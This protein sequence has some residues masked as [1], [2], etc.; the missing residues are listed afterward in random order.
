VFQLSKLGRDACDALAKQSV[1][2]VMIRTLRLTSQAALSNIANDSTELLSARNQVRLAAATVLGNL[3]NAS[4]DSSTR[5]ALAGG[6]EYAL[7]TLQQLFGLP[8]GFQN[9]SQ[10]RQYVLIDPPGAE[11][12]VAHQAIRILCGYYTVIC[13]DLAVPK[14]WERLSINYVENVTAVIN[15]VGAILHYPAPVLQSALCTLLAAIAEC[16]GNEI[17]RP[18]II[19][20]TLRDLVHLV[21]GGPQGVH[22]SDRQLQEQGE[23]VL[24]ALG[25]DDG[26]DDVHR[27]S[28]NP[29][30][31]R[32]WARIQAS[33]EFQTLTSLALKQ[34]ASEF[35]KVPAENIL[36]KAKEVSTHC[37]F[38]ATL[39][40]FF[41]NHKGAP[42]YEPPLWLRGFVGSET[43]PKPSVEV[44]EKL[45][46]ISK[47]YVTSWAKQLGFALE[48]SAFGPL[49]D[50]AAVSI[51]GIM[52][53]MP[54]WYVEMFKQTIPSLL[55]RRYYLLPYARQGH[56]SML[57]EP[58]LPELP[59]SIVVPSSRHLTKQFGSILQKIIL[60]HDPVVALEGSNSERSSSSN[61]QEWTL[62]VRE[63][64]KCPNEEFIENLLDCLRRFPSI[65]SLVLMG[66]S[67]F[68]YR[69]DI[70]AIAK[71]VRFLP[72]SV[73]WLTFDNLLCRGKDVALVAKAISLRRTLS[74]NLSG[75]SIRESGLSGRDLQPILS[76]M[77]PT[78]ARSSLNSSTP[79]AKLRVRWL[80]FSGN[81]LTDAHCA[82]IIDAVANASTATSAV[83]GLDFSNNAILGFPTKMFQAL[84]NEEKDSSIMPLLGSESSPGTLHEL[85]IGNMPVGS[86]AASALLRRAASP[87]SRLRALGLGGCRLT[88]DSILTCALVEALE[89]GT[90]LSEVDLSDNVL[91]EVSG[92]EICLALRVHCPHFIGLNGCKGLRELD[93]S[94]IQEAMLSVRAHYAENLL[95][96]AK[97]DLL[98]RAKSDFTEVRR[99]QSQWSSTYPSMWE[100]DSALAVA[101][102]PSNGDLDLFAGSSNSMISGSSSFEMASASSSSFSSSSMSMGTVS[103]NAGEPTMH[104]MV[105]DILQDERDGFR[106]RLCV[107]FSIPLVHFG[108]D[109]QPLACASI[110]YET[111]RQMLMQTFQDAKRDI[112]LSFGFATLDRLRSEV[113]LHCRAIH[114]SGHGCRDALLFE[115]Q[116]GGARP[117]ATSVLRDL[118]GSGSGGPGT[119]KVKL[120]FVSACHSEYAGQAFVDAGVPHV[121]CV[122]VS[123][124]LQ[125]T[126][127]QA[128]TR[129]FYL[130]LA[131]GGTV[132]RAFQVATQA[133]R[134]QEQSRVSGMAASMAPA[135]RP[136][137]ADK[138]LLLPL[139]GNHDVP[140]FPGRSE[141]KRWPSGDAIVSGLPEDQERQEERRKLWWGSFVSSALPK[142]FL[143][144]NVQAYDLL[145]AIMTRRI[146]S[147]TGPSGIGKLSLASFVVNYALRR[148]NFP[149]GA[150]LIRANDMESVSELVKK[151][152][153]R[154][155]DPHSAPNS[156]GGRSFKTA[157]LSF[158]EDDNADA[159]EVR[160]E[161]LFE[162]LRYRK[163][164]L[165]LCGCDKLDN[166]DPSFRTFLGRLADEVEG[167]CI[168]M[169]SSKS[170]GRIPGYTVTNIK[171]NS[172]HHRDAALL[173]LRLALSIRLCTPVDIA[174]LMT[175]METSREVANPY[176]VLDA[177]GEH[178]FLKPL[179][180]NPRR[181]MDETHALTNQRFATIIEQCQIVMANQTQVVRSIPAGPVNSKQVSSS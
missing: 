27:A 72:E 160:R 162:L 21:L 6:V 117:V 124:R 80:D 1:A 99:S 95:A 167:M 58:L 166:N 53:S 151:L 180:G 153:D 145:A 113:T 82:S 77:Q 177:I 93:R 178:P 38:A 147:C 149:Q 125:D 24:I 127:A 159:E 17:F 131:I 45:C 37:A 75:L 19:N 157:S 12:E 28:G 68:E 36:L 120:A 108:P 152:R 89:T 144:R 60:T 155:V 34:K 134:A 33:L 129:W 46:T 92:K 97:R 135:I 8:E 123:E 105:H 98:T 114:Y 59:L 83:R 73:Q 74:M 103:P 171:L 70:K 16:P 100:S 15:T 104:P 161:Q 39:R 130:E 179:N 44:D 84:F 2:R 67:D 175:S 133:V 3:A 66:P 9:S 4:A 22:L 50:D 71:L 31:L 61:L 23:D 7:E 146:V 142:E 63:C 18:Q 35:W 122:K 10:S 96:K 48:P 57:S 106:P 43:N 91:G 64:I 81:S 109:G 13:K 128:F 41:S 143:G 170:I 30:V 76:L 42:V 107:L 85:F 47:N 116:V 78:V 148:G 150:I 25:F 101:S 112:N 26:I 119:S 40:R 69:I 121:V 126:A 14:R 154:T 90:H 111:E 137:Q 5:V 52:R 158:G 168:L 118:A 172:L 169:T 55:E 49:R 138:F 174:K 54:A 139:D 87:H 163:F 141:L 156:H 20:S 110:E 56:R 29:E 176:T 140:I 11:I 132:R 88:G 62:C 136:D 173:F 165:L 51:D 86:R 94:F 32:V 65:T 102:S 79:P 181:I 115:D 164:L